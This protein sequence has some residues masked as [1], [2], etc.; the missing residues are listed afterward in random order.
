[1]VSPGSTPLPHFRSLSAWCSTGAV[2]LR[3]S[4]RKYYRGWFNRRRIRCAA[5]PVRTATTV[6]VHDLAERLGHVANFVIGEPAG[7]W[8]ARVD[9]ATRS[10]TG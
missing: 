10:V 2:R 8:S 7:E 5:S 6:A 9:A 3:Q 1:M 4:V